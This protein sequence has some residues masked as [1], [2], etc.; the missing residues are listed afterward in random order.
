V[1]SG[2]AFSI[3][4]VARSPGG[5]DLNYAGTVTFGSTDLFA[6]LPFPY[7]FSAVDNGRQEFRV[8]LRTPGPQT[9]TVTD[10]GGSL[11]PGSLTMMVTGFAGDIP[12]LTAWMQIALALLLGAVGVSLSRMGK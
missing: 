4:I 8:V 1:A 5:Q 2:Q 9:I 10:V 7:T 6:T 3:F 12:M 11:T